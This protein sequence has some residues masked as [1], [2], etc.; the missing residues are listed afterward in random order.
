MHFSRLEN[1][2][3]YMRVANVLVSTS[4]FGEGFQN[5]VAEGMSSGCAVVSTRVGSAEEIIGELGAICE[6]GDIESLVIAVET[7]LATSRSY[8][9]MQNRYDSIVA[10]FGLKELVDRTE[11]ALLDVLKVA[12]R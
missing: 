12:R 8:E 6:P 4:L 1:P 11:S 7:F 5:V 9:L 2:E 10:R 3:L